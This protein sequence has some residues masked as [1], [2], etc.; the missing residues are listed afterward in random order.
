MT[1]PNKNII[2]VGV[3]GQGVVL[4]SNVLAQVCLNAEQDIK[5][6]EVHGMS[7]RGGSVSSHLRYGEKVFSPLI[8]LGEAD[9]VVSFEWMEALR[10]LEFLKPGGILVVS[11]QKIVPVSVTFGMGDYPDDVEERIK[12][13]G[14]DLISLDALGIA[15]ELGNS[16]VVSTVMLGALSNHLKLTEKQW[17]EAIAQSVPPKSLEM[18]EKA[19]EAGRKCLE[20]VAQ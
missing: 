12:E 19:F 18:N 3:G 17:L 9:I 8:P 16:K 13:R 15:Q 5:K 14:F 7:Q 20:A 6:A 2:F 10:Y 11:T 4:A 1:M